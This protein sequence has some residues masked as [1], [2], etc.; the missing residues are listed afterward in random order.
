[1]AGNAGMGRPKG[2]RN[3]RAAELLALAGDGE[4]PVEFGLRI[5]R[6]EKASLEQRL[7]AARF[8]A[9]FLHPRPAPPP[10]DA[11][12]ELPETDT[13]E[14]M[15]NAAAAVLRAVADGTINATDGIHL[16]G[17]LDFKR[18]TVERL[19]D[20]RRHEASRREIEARTRNVLK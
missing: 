9:P 14:G 19:A 6:D 17:I 16:V 4:T 7:Q 1:M 20:E 3:R 12:F 2:S 18:M 15:S 10:E 11:G 5:M 8:A 13:R